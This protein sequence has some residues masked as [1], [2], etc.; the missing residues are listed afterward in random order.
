M[1]RINNL[2]S[3]REAARRACK[4]HGIS[5]KDTTVYV[6]GFSGEIDNVTVEGVYL[7]NNGVHW[8]YGESRIG[9]LYG[10]YERLLV[11]R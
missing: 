5:I 3:L 6:L 2:S 9:L 4:N 11:V 7:H 10:T 8:Y 1:K